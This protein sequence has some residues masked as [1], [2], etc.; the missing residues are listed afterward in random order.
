MCYFMSWDH[1]TFWQMK[2]ICKIIMVLLLVKQKQL[3]YSTPATV[4]LKSS[5]VLSV[6]GSFLLA[7]FQNGVEFYWSLF[8][9]AGM[10]LKGE[11]KCGRSL[12]WAYVCTFLGPLVLLVNSVHE[13]A[14]CVCFDTIPVWLPSFLLNGLKEQSSSSGSVFSLFLFKRRKCFYKQ[15]NKQ[16]SLTVRFY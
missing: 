16:D 3:F 8:S 9:R 7:S 1:I 6:P 4:S 15:A 5:F 13:E 10:R 11:K 12:R 2:W 14:V